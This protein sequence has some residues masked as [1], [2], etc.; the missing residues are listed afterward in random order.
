MEKHLKLLFSVLIALTVAFTGMASPAYADDPVTDSN[1]VEAVAN[2]ERDKQFFD[3]SGL[4]RLSRTVANFRTAPAISTAVIVYPLPADAETSPFWD[5]RQ[6]VIFYT[7]LSMNDIMD[8]YRVEL[9]DNGAIEREIV[10]F[11]D[12]DAEGWFSIV[13]D[14]W[15]PAGNLAVVVQGVR[16]SPDRYV[17][18]IRLEK[19]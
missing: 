5:T 2:G 10:T 3:L 13:F 12:E 7:A 8:F 9:A 4:W 11:Y 17:V 19:V 1:Q 16:L 18:S 15:E 14:R 6:T